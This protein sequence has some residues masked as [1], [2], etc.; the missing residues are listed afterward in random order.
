MF[1]VNS[2]LHFQC[3]FLAPFSVKSTLKSTLNFYTLLRVLSTLKRVGPYVIFGGVKFHTLSVDF[4]LL[5]SVMTLLAPNYILH[6]LLLK[7]V[8]L[9]QIYRVHLQGHL[10]WSKIAHSKCWFN[11]SSICY[12]TLSTKWH[13]RHLSTP[14]DRST[15]NKCV[16]HHA[17]KKLL[18]MNLQQLQNYADLFYLPI[19]L[20]ISQGQTAQ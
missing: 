14:T 9:T 7:S 10:W 13:F 4:T 16:G 18:K 15:N 1:G 20:D 6:S 2:I 8:K 11:T 17:K 12:D 19:T 5:R 3:K